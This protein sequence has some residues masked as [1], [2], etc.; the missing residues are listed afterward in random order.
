MFCDE[1]HGKSGGAG[2]LCNAC[3]VAGGF[4]CKYEADT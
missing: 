3:K 1:T 4:A 2:A